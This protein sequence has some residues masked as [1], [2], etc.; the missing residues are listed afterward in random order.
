MPKTRI[1]SAE[2]GSAH[3]ERASRNVLASESRPGGSRG[4]PERS[5]KR[6][7]G[8]ERWQINRKER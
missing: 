2:R 1:S 8:G 3:G 5:R 4:G 6:S 7:A